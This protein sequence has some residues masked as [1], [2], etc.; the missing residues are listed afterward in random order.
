MY[1]I[2]FD[3]IFSDSSQVYEESNHTS[4]E[5]ESIL[6]SSQ[7]SSKKTRSKR[8]YSVSEN[9]SLNKQTRQVTINEPSVEDCRE[10]FLQDIEKELWNDNTLKDILNS[11][12]KSDNKQMMSNASHTPIVI[13]KTVE[14]T[15]KH[16]VEVF[17]DSLPNTQTFKNILNIFDDID[18]DIKKLLLG[19]NTIVRNTSSP[20]SIPLPYKSLASF[21]PPVTNASN[22][23]NNT[24]PNDNVN[25]E[26]DG[27]CI[28]QSIEEED[29]EI[30]N[31]NNHESSNIEEI[32]VEPL[33]S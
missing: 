29:K 18:D 6:S 30:P 8:N 17:V 32:D 9:P 27:G 14:Q 13:E 26:Y 11:N 12:Q 4:A 20:S 24:S 16:K 31:P 21:Q 22:N 19:E 25:D 2:L 28:L 7:M 3:L 5:L 1:Y 15:M 23:V 10:A 33:P